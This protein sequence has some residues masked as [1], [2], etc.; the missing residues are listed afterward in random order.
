MDQ[1]SPAGKIGNQ[2]LRPLRIAFLVDPELNSDLVLDGVFANCYSRW[3]GRFS[4]I[5][6]CRIGEIVPEYWPWLLRFDPDVVYSYVRLEDAAVLEIH[7]RIAPADYVFHREV[8]EDNPRP[9]AFSPSMSLTALSSMSTIFRLA[10]HSPVAD[11][12]K[13][14]VLDSWPTEKPTRFLTDNLGTY[15]ASVESRMYP[16]DAKSVSGLMTIVSDEYFEDRRL[17]VPKDLDRVPNESSAL[18]EFISGRVTSMS[19]LSALFAPRLEIRDYRWSGGFNLVI[20]DTFEDRMLFWNARLLIPTYLDTDLCC[21]RITMD[22]IQDPEM[23]SLLTDLINRRNYVTDGAGGQAQ[24]VIRSASHCEDQLIEAMAILRKSKVWSAFGHIEV[25]P[26]GHV[27]PE[28]GDEHTGV[29]LTDGAT[30][31]HGWQTFSWQF[32]HATPPVRTPEHL[33]DAPAGQRFTLGIWALDLA[34]QYDSNAPRLSRANIWMLPKRWR[35]SNAFITR[36]RTQVLIQN[37]LHTRTEG[38]GYLSVFPSVNNVLE[39]VTVP[40]LE[41]ALRNAFCLPSTPWRI[42]V[43]DPPWPQEKASWMQPSNESSYLLGV[44]GMTGDLATAMDLLLRPFF[45][46]MFASL[47]GTPNLNDADTAPIEKALSRRASARPDFSLRNEDDIRAL[48]TLALK[49][50]QNLKTPK[51]HVTLQK[52]QADWDAHLQRQ[53]PEE[54]KSMT[55]LSEAEV[56]EEYDRLRLSLEGK[57]SMMRDRRMLFQ[58]YSWTCQ[59]CRHKNWSDFQ[60][61]QASL[62]CDICRK[63]T[64]LPISVPWHFR[65]N[66]FLIESLRYRSVLSVIWVLAALRGRALKSFMYVGSTSFGFS[67][68]GYAPDAEMDLLAIVDGRSIMCEVKTSWRSLRPNDLIGFAELALKFRPDIAMLAVMKGEQKMQAQIQELREK[69]N[70]AGIEFQLLTE[71]DYRAEDD[72]PLL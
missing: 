3:G 10:R 35:L 25:V 22:H 39:S 26:G 56:E 66:E 40:T 30:Q 29:L 53:W 15:G 48:A 54:K 28:I 65:P 51:T 41:Q 43:G 63:H 18:R 9:S 50:A 38:Q 42:D 46:E 55:H 52:L 44:L 6:P 14:K 49:A 1:T 70:A 8:K 61:L 2:R 13:V 58:G 21:L 45:V 64:Q 31:T 57:L 67:H 62:T 5:V 59:S 47:G 60:H 20:G 34:L 36:S 11:G 7:E 19:L 27:I 37:I 4:L 23:L 68:D 32:P 33:N 69:L 24:L 72:L 17:G 12:P 71:S 16:N